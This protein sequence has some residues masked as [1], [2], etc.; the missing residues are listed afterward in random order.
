MVFFLFRMEDLIVKYIAKHGS[1]GLFDG[2]EN[3]D[4]SY[5]L[6]SPRFETSD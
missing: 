6:A 5:E 1:L 3:E 2:T 4:M